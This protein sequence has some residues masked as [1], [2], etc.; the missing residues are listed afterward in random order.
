MPHLT[1]TQPRADLLRAIAAGKV[2]DAGEKALADH[3]ATAGTQ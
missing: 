1:I 2:T 3:D